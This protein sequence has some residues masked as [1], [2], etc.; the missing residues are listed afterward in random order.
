MLNIA[1]W[2]ST[3]E[4]VIFFGENASNQKLKNLNLAEPQDSSLSSD[5]R[6]RY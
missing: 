2:N 6:I 4:M 1:G 3:C 5:F